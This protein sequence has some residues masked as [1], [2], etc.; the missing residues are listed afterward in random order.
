LLT[1]SFRAKGLSKR[2][3]T[4]TVPSS[5]ER[6]Q[7]AVSTGAEIGPTPPPLSTGAF[8]IRAAEDE[9]TDRTAFKLSSAR[10][11]QYW[12]DRGAPPKIDSK[13]KIR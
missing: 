6:K 13:E 12:L 4:F 10:R 9:R 8:A 3:D 7:Q 11:G 5:G 1:R 2:L